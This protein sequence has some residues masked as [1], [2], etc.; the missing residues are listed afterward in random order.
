[1]RLVK[2][3]AFA[4]RVHVVRLMN[5]VV[6]ELFSL[7]SKENFPPF[8]VIDFAYN[9][10]PEHTRFRELMVTWYTWHDGISLSDRMLT[11]E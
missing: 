3:Y 5:D 6:W 11:T 8:P 9:D 1:M 4:D 2:L 10:I 7:R